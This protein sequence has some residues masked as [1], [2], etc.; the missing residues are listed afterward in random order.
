MDMVEAYLTGLKEIRST[1]G[2]APETSY[3]GPL[4]N[5][6]NEVGHKLK[7][8]VRCVG[9]VADTGAGHPDFGFYTSDQFQKTKDAKPL[10][11]VLT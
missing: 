9:Q 5:L 8:K 7:P 4:E 1:G 3:Y 6:L 2:A 10:P 11:G